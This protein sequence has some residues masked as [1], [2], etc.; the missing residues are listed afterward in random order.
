MLPIPPKKTKRRNNITK[1]NHRRSSTPPETNFHHRRSQS[2]PPENTID[3]RT[4]LANLICF[5]FSLKS[6]IEG[7][8]QLEEGKTEDEFWGVTK[9]EEEAF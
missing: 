9:K 6:C 1:Q 4:Q 5:E 8:N 3:R 7:I 2:S